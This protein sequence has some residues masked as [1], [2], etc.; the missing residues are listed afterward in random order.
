MSRA[1]LC[2]H[3]GVDADARPHG[4]RDHQKLHGIDDGEGGEAGVRISADEEAVDH[5]V[6]GLDEL[7]QHDGRREFE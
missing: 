3:H 6:K 1:E 5:V 4:E 7:R 2:R